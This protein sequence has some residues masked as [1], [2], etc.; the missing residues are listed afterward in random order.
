MKSLLTCC[1]PYLKLD[2]FATEFNGFD[3]KNKNVGSIKIEKSR[4]SSIIV[5]ERNKRMLTRSWP[6]MCLLDAV[7]LRVIILTRIQ[8]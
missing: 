4:E 5:V 1:V 2:L 8:Y 3:L 7:F 6:P